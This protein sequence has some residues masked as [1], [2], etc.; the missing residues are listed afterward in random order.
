MTALAHAQPEQVFRAC[1]LLGATA[2]QL[3]TA[4]AACR[5]SAAVTWVGRAQEQYQQ[6]LADLASD[7]VQVRSAFDLACDALLSYGQALAYAQP[8]ALEADRLEAL[9]DE[10]PLARVPALRWEA[11][12]TE[13]AAAARLINTLHDLA[14]RA[15]RSSGWTTAQ[16]DAANFATGMADYVKGLGATVGAA[17]ASLP[18]VGSSDD[19]AQARHELGQ[20]VVDAAQPWKQVQE[21]LDAIQHG[22]GFRAGG[23]FA[24]AA[25]MRRPGMR[26][27]K[28]VKIFGYQDELSVALLSVMRRGMDGAPLSIWAAARIQNKLVSDFKRLE[29]VKLP[30]LDELLS[31]PVD[32][33][34]HESHAG[35]TMWKHVGRDADFLRFRQSMESRREGRGKA[36]SFDS[37]DQAERLVDQVLS[38]RADAIRQWYAGDKR[39]KEFDLPLAEP[40]GIVLNARGIVVPASAVRVVLEKAKKGTVC[41]ATAYLM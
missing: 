14:A 4:V 12:Q 16:H 17:F 3:A 18:G 11:T 6:R 40:V 24:M 31:S 21:L 1:A 34:H 5:R 39:S 7:L 35:H 2:D 22:M 33:T 9:G 37:L 20:Q 15:P 23:A 28:S 27:S 36:A 32:L 30:S 13:L 19:R 38:A 25:V 26:E 41:V 8:L 10:T 29:R